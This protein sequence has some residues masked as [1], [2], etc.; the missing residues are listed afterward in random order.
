MIQNK[1]PEK[2][3]HHSEKFLLLC[4]LH[5]LTFVTLGLLKNTPMA[6]KRAARRV[7]LR[8]ESPPVFFCPRQ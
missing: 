1:S 8:G 2:H 4:A 7:T 6:E 3:D 5:H